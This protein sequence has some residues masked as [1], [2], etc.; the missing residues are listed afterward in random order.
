MKQQTTIPQSSFSFLT[1]L[2]AN[3]DRDWFNANKARYQ[4][5]HAV[6]CGFGD[7][8]LEKMR[9]HDTL[10]TPSGKASLFRIYA[11]TRFSKDKAPYKTHWGFRISRATAEL[12]GGYYFHLEPGHSFAA[13]GF[14]GPNPDDL[15]RIREDIDRNYEDWYELFARPEMQETFG[16]LDGEKV[17]TAPKGYSVDH[18]GIEWLRHKQFILTR[19]FTDEEVLAP[20]FIDKLDQTFRNLRP[21]FDYMSEVLT[22]NS[23]GESIL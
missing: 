12:R 19:R 21:F 14:F 7:A 15:K 20:D 2:K 18:P 4:Q 10:S 9:A 23:D 8:L 11:D 17:T 16:H 13:G 5:E 22:T 1:D 3:N 6:V